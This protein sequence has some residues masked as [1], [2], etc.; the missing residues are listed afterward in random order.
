MAT[1]AVWC[2][3]V[4]QFPSEDVRKALGARID[5]TEQQVQVILPFPS[6]ILT[7]AQNIFLAA[8]LWLW[9]SENAMLH[10]RSLQSG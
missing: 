6:L 2:T 1:P 9:S 10:A 5:L 3:A 7:L 8:H 4:H